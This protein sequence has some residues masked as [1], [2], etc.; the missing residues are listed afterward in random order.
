[1]RFEGEAVDLRLELTSF[2][3]RCHPHLSAENETRAGVITDVTGQREM[4]I[5]VNLRL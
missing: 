5:R 1:M 3:R 4:E 2:P